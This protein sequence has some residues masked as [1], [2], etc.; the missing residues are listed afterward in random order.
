MGP[1]CKFC[2]RRCFVHI[3]YDWPE[4]IIKAYGTSTIAATCP[5]G[6]KFEK[7]KT[8]YCYD[9]AMAAKEQA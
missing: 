2:D 6:Q 3:T 1:Y 5:G 4:H 7:Q 8:G 9:D